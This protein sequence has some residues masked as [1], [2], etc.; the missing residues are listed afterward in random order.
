MSF[1]SSMAV[2]IGSYLPVRLIKD[3]FLVPNLKTNL[4]SV[5]QMGENGYSLYFD[6]GMCFI[7]DKKNKH[8]FIA[9]IEVK[10]RNFPIYWS[11]IHNTSMR[12]EVDKGSQFRS[13]NLCFQGTP[14]F[15]VNHHKI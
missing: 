13:P 14:I 15:R 7:Y 9:K 8:Q 4:L 5:G 2:T 1:D 11:Y 6:N 3:V 10:E 12:A